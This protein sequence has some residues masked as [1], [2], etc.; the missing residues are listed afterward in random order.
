MRDDC[1]DCSRVAIE[2]NLAYEDKVQWFPRYFPKPL[3]IRSRMCAECHAR[4]VWERIE[5]G[6][7]KNLCQSHAEIR[8]LPPVRTSK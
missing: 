3:G 4:P 6:V 2:A 8:G 5:G 7:S 1:D